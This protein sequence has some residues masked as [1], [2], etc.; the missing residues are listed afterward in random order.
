MKMEQIIK[1]GK[2]VGIKKV[3][4]PGD[5]MFEQFGEFILLDKEPTAKDYENLINKVSQQVIG[6]IQ[7]SG[8]VWNCENF[9]VITKKKEDFDYELPEGKIGTL[10]L[11]V[12]ITRI[13]EEG[14]N[15]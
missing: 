11:K 6:Y 8:K 9:E 3:F 13:V 7:S 10:G 4:E 5:K 14:E 2:I 15:V 12:A 1:D